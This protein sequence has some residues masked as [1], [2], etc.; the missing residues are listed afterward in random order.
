MD[1]DILPAFDDLPT[2]T[3]PALCTVP[4][5]DLLR[6][7]DQWTPAG[8]ANQPDG[9]LRVT[10]EDLVAL[11][12]AGQDRTLPRP[13]LKLGHTDGRFQDPD[14]L[15]TGFPHADGQPALGRLVNLR[16][17][18]DGTAL[19]CDVFGI[20][21]WLAYIWPSAFPH[22]SIEWLPGDWMSAWYPQ[23]ARH[24]LVLTGLALLGEAWPAIAVLEDVPALF[25]ITPTPI[26]LPDQE[27]TL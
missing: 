4:N 23:A 18:E 27:A 15:D 14:G 11:V 19:R 7:G 21:A 10:A 22:R 2:V 24:P 1:D 6:V 5:V 13:V 25:G 3:L 12:A 20:P 8:G 16:L 9:T 26:V 17:A